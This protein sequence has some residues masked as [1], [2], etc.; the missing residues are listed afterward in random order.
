MSSNNII[1]DYGSQSAVA[2]WFNDYFTE[3]D[4][5]I[6]PWLLTGILIG[7]ITFGPGFLLWLVSM[8]P[9]DQL[10]N[11]GAS[12]RAHQIV[13]LIAG[14]LTL[15]VGVVVLA[16][17]ARPSL[18][19]ITPAGI[20]KIWL[21]LGL[22]PLN[23]PLVRWSTVT[24]A[25]IAKPDGLTDL[26]LY[27]LVFK[28][29]QGTDSMKLTL[30]ELEGEE[31]RRDLLDA[32]SQHVKNI[33]PDV[34]EAL[35]P[36]RA[37]SFTEI[38][39]DALSAPPGRERLLPLDKHM[40]L[41]TRYKIER[42]L[43]AGGQGTVYLAHDSQENALVVL[44]ETI[45]PVYADLI[46]RKQAL[47][48]FHK[49]AFA[50][51]SAQHSNIVKFRRSFVAD[52]RAYLVLEFVDG[53]TLNEIINRQGPSSPAKSKQFASDMCDILTALHSL[54]PPLV[55]R[56]F[57]PDNLM[58]GD[59]DKLVLI[60]FAVAVDGDKT[61][62]DVAGKASYMAPEQFK[63]KP[64]PQSDVYSLGCT[65]YFLLTGLHPEPL[66]ECWPMLANDTVPK[67]LNDFVV[68]CTKLDTNDRFKSAAE[69]KQELQKIQ[70]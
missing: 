62:A 34:I 22:I 41:D 63:G 6:M 5:R 13:Q 19:E 48:A 49:E 31:K 3:R 59:S 4:R 58:V 67:E 2:R 29:S 56:D 53:T 64:T 15:S 20:R 14:T 16:R 50:L 68:R 33:D 12:V 37:L 47:E 27:Q 21:V 39:L 51:E 60:D 44:K 54:T 10:G 42:R 43:G 18:I 9:V 30:G 57:T 55:H 24:F 23:G 7:F 69:A 52:H 8:L 46:T 36:T 11:S 28:D 38:W 40:L 66:D 70:V 45:L 32:I 17:V 26:D 35:M 61:S 1:I 65:L 25:R